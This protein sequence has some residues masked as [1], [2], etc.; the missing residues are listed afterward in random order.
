MEFQ[1][2]SFQNL[3]SWLLRL[4]KL[5]LTVFDDIKD[6]AAATV[7]AI[8]VVVAATV[9]AGLGSWLWWIQQDFAPG[10]DQKNLEVF[11]KSLVLGG[12]FQSALWFLWVYISAMVLTRGLGAS[13]D[14]NQ[15]VRTMGLAFA[16]MAISVLMVIRVLTVP[17]GVIG[18]G[19][20]LLLSNVAIQATTTADS[21]QVVLANVVGFLVFAIVLGILANISEVYNWGGLAP[22][23]F[24]FNLNP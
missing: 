11:F 17:F 12:I 5:D 21:R 15:M 2:A 19:A 18:I 13:A 14:I 4:A 1:G 24:F 7:P 16:P 22:G 23:L 8:A 3:G 10:V 6:E 9:L 20:T